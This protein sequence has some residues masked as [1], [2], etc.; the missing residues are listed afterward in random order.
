[1][2]L[3]SSVLA[4]GQGPA[5]QLLANAAPD[6][7]A[8]CEG[9]Y[10]WLRLNLCEV[11]TRVLGLCAGR[12]RFRELR[13]EGL[14]PVTV[15]VSPLVEKAQGSMSLAFAASM[16]A[17]L[18]QWPLRKDVALLAEVDTRGTLLPVGGLQ[19]KAKALQAVGVKTLVLARGSADAPELRA[20]QAAFP[21]VLE[22]DEVWQAFGKCF[23]PP[24]RQPPRA[25]LALQHD[26]APG[27][28]SRG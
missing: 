25:A 3:V 1:M 9:A 5:M 13:D 26:G 6:M 15:S 7:R 18:V 4:G 19:G 10:L 23:A 24:P 22:C 8:S 17:A 21:L 11:C 28:S 12:A 20:L 27:K 14:P 2:E 16:A